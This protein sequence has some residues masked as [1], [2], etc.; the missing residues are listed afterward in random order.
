MG[1]GNIK[2]PA[3]YII[4]EIR[5]WL[6]NHGYGHGHV[7]VVDSVNIIISSK[8]SSD[9]L[10]EF[11]KD[12][13]CE[14]HLNGVSF[15]GNGVKNKFK[16]GCNHKE[17]SAFRSYLHDWLNDRNFPIRFSMVTN[18]ILLHVT[19][20]LSYSQINEFE[21]EFDVKLKEYLMKCS[22]DLIKYE[23]R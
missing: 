22:S 12:F 4:S 10:E 19:K 2:N 3:N 1:V 14:I 17:L 15:D 8:I 20:E 18:G 5:N 13:G 11:K 16:Y 9:D 7:F 23:F 21:D 6:L